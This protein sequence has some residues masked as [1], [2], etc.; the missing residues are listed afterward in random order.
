MESKVRLE[1]TKWSR[2][3]FLQ[4]ATVAGASAGV[5]AL[6]GCA[7]APKE[8]DDKL[9]STSTS[10]GSSWLT[11]P[12]TISEDQITKTEEADVVVIGAGLSGISTAASS[13]ENGQSVIVLEKNQ[14]P[15]YTGLD[16][17]CVN[18]SLAKEHGLPEVDPYEVTRDWTR[19]SGGCRVK[20]DQVM[21]FALNSG[22]AMDW[23]CEK[24]E[25]WGCTPVL[26]AMLSNS[27]TYANFPAAIEFH[28]GPAW[29]P[30]IESFG[31]RDLIDAM[32]DQFT[33]EDGVLHYE[34]AAEQLVREGDKIIGVIGKE[35]DGSYVKYL[36]KKGVVL[37]TG[38]FAGDPEMLKDLTSFDYDSYAPEHFLNASFGTGDGHKM[39]IWEGAKM[40]QGDSP[41]M[42]LPF[43]YPYFYLNV[44]KN[45]E[46]YRNEDS[47]SVAISIDQMLQPEARTWS[48]WDSK[49][50]EEIPASLAYGG[51]MDWDQDFRVLGNDWS[52]ETEKETFAYNLEMG[53]LFMADTIEELAEKIDIPVEEF[54]KTVDRYNEIVAAG[55]DDDFGKR[56]ELLTSLSEPPYYALRMVTGLCVTVGG[57]NI[58]V[59]HQVLDESAKQIEGLYA[60]GNVSGG[61]YGVDYDQS[62]IP[63]CSLGR[64]VTDGWLLG[65]HFAAK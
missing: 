37:A 65:R 61:L 36:G 59:N 19:L 10:E 34:V 54:K 57:L 40:Q 23:A 27:D 63:G 42:F 12:E 32:I 45:G 30:S 55:V 28:N 33:K 47:F 60:V 29:D 8:V 58:N 50:E 16:F 52:L 9:T 20:A 46:R 39:G 2:R 53:D 13:L 6:T 15:R 35:K 51:G 22:K 62:T 4:M 25:A 26:S 38:D 44:N 43:T 64:C 48:V 31:S 49:W 56:K 7:G 1:Q 11:K 24:A 21:Q 3:N 17:G 41:V 5:L 14:Y 18:P